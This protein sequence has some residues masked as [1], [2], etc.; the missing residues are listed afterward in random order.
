MKAAEK[1]INDT[2]LEKLSL[3]FGDPTRMDAIAAI[4]DYVR[5]RAYDEHISLPLEPSAALPCAPSDPMCTV[6]GLV[7]MRQDFDD[8]RGL[9]AVLNE[10]LLR[11]K[12]K[13]PTIVTAGDSDSMGMGE[14][15]AEAIRVE[16]ERGVRLRKLEEVVK[17]VLAQELDDVCWRDVYTE[18][19]SLVGVTF[20][21]EL[22]PK[23]QF[24]GH[25]SRFHDSLACGTKYE[26][27]A[28]PKH[29]AASINEAL[30]TLADDKA[31]ALCVSLLSPCRGCGRVLAGGE[32]CYCT[33]DE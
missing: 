21:P 12:P 3:P 5:V 18:M 1:H 28:D 14:R 19:A 22:L 4:R 26:T 13:G 15:L 11:Y 30:M 27:K 33:R 31:R 8:A 23:V 16:Q 24:M 10:R 32:A 6:E 9:R 2:L 7:V 20:D 29:L 25:C 17:G